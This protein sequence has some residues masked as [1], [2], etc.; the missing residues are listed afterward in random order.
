[1]SISKL[2]SLFGVLVC[3]ASQV[4]PEV[5]WRASPVAKG[6]ATLYAGSFGPTPTV[7]LCSGTSGCELWS[8]VMLLDGWNHSVKFA[9]P[10]CDPEPCRFQFCSNSAGPCT[11]VAE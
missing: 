6:T 1:M 5:Y 10:S 2:L 4:A 8:P 11:D 9:M 3:G 7:R